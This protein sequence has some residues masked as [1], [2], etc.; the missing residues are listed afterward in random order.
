MN[1]LPKTFQQF[2]R[3]YPAIWRAHEELAQAC[4]DMGPLD[5]KTRELIKVAISV[6]AK[7][8][9]AAQRHAIMARENG[10][11]KEEVFQTVMMTMTTC[12]HPAAAAGWQWVS[13]AL[14]KPAKSRRAGGR[15]KA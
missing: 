9:T 7:L 5:R 14:A 6:A 12:G 11:T 10:A 13:S 3:N 15:K 8:E 4:S 1:S 2:V